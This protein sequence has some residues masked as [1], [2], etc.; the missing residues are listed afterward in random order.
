MPEAHEEPEG[1]IDSR[2][3]GEVGEVGLHRREE[4]LGQA[5]SFGEGDGGRDGRR[6]DPSS[7]SN[8][9][10]DRVEV[11]GLTVRDLKLHARGSGGSGLSR[12]DSL[13]DA[14]SSKG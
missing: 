2:A 9:N 1:V 6:D 7:K 4:R 8:G 11:E 14:R 13:G 5:S 12:D 3:L 10:D